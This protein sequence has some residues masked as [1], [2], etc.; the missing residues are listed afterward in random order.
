MIH[1]KARLNPY[2][3]ED[4]G[5]SKMVKLNK[6]HFGLIDNKIE[7]VINQVK[8]MNII[9]WESLWLNEEE[10]RKRKNCAKEL[11]VVQVIHCQNF[12]NEKYSNHTKSHIKIT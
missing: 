6:N 3:V 1:E 12:K 7:E 4:K 9:K 5:T 11:I 2:I 10:L 8:D